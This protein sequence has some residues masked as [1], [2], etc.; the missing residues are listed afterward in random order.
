MQGSVSRRT[1]LIPK[2]IYNIDVAQ[3][4]NIKTYLYVYNPINSGKK[5]TIKNN[6]SERWLVKAGGRNALSRR[7]FEMLPKC[8]SDESFKMM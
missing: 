3:H 5:R 4:S 6:E 8:C 1:K 7:I 2:K